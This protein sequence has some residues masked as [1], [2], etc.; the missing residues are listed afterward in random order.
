MICPVELTNE[1]SALG[2]NVGAS[3]RR[4][5]EALYGNCSGAG[6]EGTRGNSEGIYDLIAI[7]DDATNDEF[8]Q[9]RKTCRKRFSRVLRASGH[10]PT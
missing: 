4:D 7:M 5:H 10:P 2:G 9:G 1:M 6:I 8:H 3:R